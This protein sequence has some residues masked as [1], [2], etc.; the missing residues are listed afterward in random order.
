MSYACR[1]GR[2]PGEW[3]DEERVMRHYEAQEQRILEEIIH[4]LKTNKDK[5]VG[6][7]LYELSRNLRH[8]PDRIRQV[9][10][11][12]QGK[13]MNGVL[14]KCETQRGY[15]VVWS[16]VGEDPILCMH[17]ATGEIYE[18][19]V[20]EGQSFAVCDKCGLRYILPG[21]NVSVDWSLNDV[22]AP[23]TLDEMWGEP[24]VASGK[25]LDSVTKIGMP[26]VK[27]KVMLSQW[28]HTSWRVLGEALTDNYGNFAVNLTDTL[29]TLQ[30]GRYVLSV[31]V[32]FNDMKFTKAN[33]AWFHLNLVERPANPAWTRLLSYVTVEVNVTDG[34]GNGLQGC[35][36][37]LGTIKA[38]T[39]AS[40]VAKFNYVPLGNYRLKVVRNGYK[41]HQA[42]VDLGHPFEIY[43]LNVNM[44]EYTAADFMVLILA[45]GAFFA[46]ITAPLW[47]PKIVGKEHS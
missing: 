33:D 13:W 32:N 23:N 10:E 44:V 12:N 18:V 4:Y 9:V 37:N 1:V 27:V 6:V 22:V 35:M 15:Y 36:V 30:P 47:V 8:R 39:D 3:S 26:Q 41:P 31:D 24:F 17:E 16:R 43:I 38:V 29:K 5:G 14:G 34:K 20:K 21:G 25:V 40:G 2:P 7:S 19:V 45:V 42:E 11:K 46:A 28:P